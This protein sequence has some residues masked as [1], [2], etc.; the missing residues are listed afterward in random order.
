MVIGLRFDNDATNPIEE[1]RGP[2]EVVRQIGGRAAEER[3]GSSGA[4][5]SLSWRRSH[6]SC[7]AQ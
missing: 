7:L 6:L 5:I 2:D 1:E 3:A 4:R